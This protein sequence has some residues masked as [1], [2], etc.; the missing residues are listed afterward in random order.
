MGTYKPMGVGDVLDAAHEA[1]K[2]AGDQLGGYLPKSNP[3]IVVLLRNGKYLIAGDTGLPDYAVLVNAAKLRLA[4]GTML[5]GVVRLYHRPSQKVV[6]VLAVVTRTSRPDI[7][8]YFAQ[9]AAH[10]VLSLPG[11][12]KF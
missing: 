11:T 9:A 5:P 8:E 3:F 6:G 1:A 4:A 10:A 12:V 2:A 7:D